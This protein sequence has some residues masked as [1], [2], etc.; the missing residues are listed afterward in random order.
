MHCR[1]CKTASELMVASKSFNASGKANRSY[2][3]RECNRIR[4]VEYRNTDRGKAAT[5][6]AIEK[7]ETRNTDRRQAWYAVRNVHREPCL[8]CGDPNSH[9]HHPDPKNKLDIMFLCPLHHKAIHK[10]SSS[11]IM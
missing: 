4:G 8:V 7:Y 9:R 6:K 1:V 5:R 3:C 2:I 10:Q 11:V